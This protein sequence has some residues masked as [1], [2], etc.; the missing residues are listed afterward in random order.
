MRA[1]RSAGQLIVSGTL[2]DG[3]PRLDSANSNTFSKGGLARWPNNISH[4]RSQ[5]QFRSSKQV[6][7][8]HGLGDH[9]MKWQNCIVT[10]VKGQAEKVGVLPGWKIHMV[11]GNPCKTD[12]EIT[13]FVFEASW[14]WRSWKVG[15]ITDYKFILSEQ[16][17]KKKKTIEDEV[18]RLARLP[19]EGPYDKAHL[20]EVEEKY[21]FQGYINRAEDR[22]VTLPQLQRMVRWVDDHCHRWRDKTTRLKLKLGGISM[23]HIVDWLV[24]PATLKNDCAFVEL[25]TTQSQPPSWFIIHWWGEKLVDF[26]KCLQL[27]AST[28]SLPKDAG[29]WIG[30]FGRRQHSTTREIAEDFT[31]TL[32][33]RAMS[34]TN[35]HVLMT[36]EPRV[37]YVKEGVTHA[38]GPA[39]SF[40]RIWCN[41]EAMMCCYNL[42]EGVDPVV[43][44]AAMQGQEPVL[45]TSGLTEAEEHQELVNPSA[46]FKAKMNRE[47]AFPLD[48]I[49]AGLNFRVQDAQSSD[50][51]DKTRILNCI[52]ERE[53]GLPSLEKHELYDKANAR[54]RALIAT[55]CWRRVM[56]G[57]ST[58][59]LQTKISESLRN[60]IWDDTIALSMAWCLGVVE[61][62]P[63]VMRSIHG[64]ITHL[65]L[66]FKGMN[67][68]DTIMQDMALNLQGVKELRIDLAQN[69]EITNIGVANFIQAIPPKMRTL[70]LNLTG[71]G[72]SPQF[73]ASGNSI[74]SIREAIYDESQK[75]SLCTTVN[76]APH[77]K[78]E[79]DKKGMVFTSKKSK[80]HV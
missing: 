18:L 34:A 25:L 74:E 10:S 46:G 70:V 31:K 60:D 77:P 73:V 75:G 58:Y 57:V 56:A 52:A 39:T 5:L 35:F 80:V 47:K 49:E 71:T 17:E 64:N 19:F 9:G 2:V 12:E 24:K 53:L 42:P 78:E 22:A 33:F 20:D 23:Y 69:P 51:M 41:M 72:A 15:F 40:S 67:L 7:F 65:T 55:T 11:D 38:Q 61:R 6:E 16:I 43:D 3:G 68:D 37:E 8:G 50:A 76:L 1:S 54:L 79:R 30:A 21:K 28:R 63:F 4:T 66:D 29:Y 36:L 48:V 13:H 59:E 27:H 45:V 62:M 32:F 14:Q 26:M 44:I